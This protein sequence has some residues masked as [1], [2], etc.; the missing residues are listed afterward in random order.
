MTTPTSNIHRTFFDLP[1]DESSDIDQVE[2]LANFSS[3]GRLTWAQLLESDRVLIVSEAGVGKS[4]ECQRQQQQLWHEGESA[5]FVEL[6][7]LATDPLESQ[8]SA[9]E[10]CRFDSWLSAQTERAT[11]FLDSVDELKLT[12]GSFELTLKRFAK[13]L[14]GHLARTRIVLTTRPIAVDRDLVYRWLP[15]PPPVEVFVPETYF[16]N[17]AMRVD[18]RKDQANAS[19]VPQ[20]RFVALSPLNEQQM[21]TLATIE[22]IA[23]PA[24]L[25]QAIESQNAHDFAKRPLDF[26]ELCGDWKAYSRIRSHREQVSHNI[27]V[28]LRPRGDRRERLALAPERAREGTERLALAALLTRRF[29]IWRGQDRDRARGDSALDPSKILADWT[30]DELKTLLERPLFGFATYGRVRFHNRSVIEF[31]AAERLRGLLHKGMS[32]L[33]LKRLLFVTTPVGLPIVKPTMQPVA[34]WLA[35]HYPAIRAEVLQRDPSILLRYADPGSLDLAMRTEALQQYVV[36]YGTGGWRGQHVPAL[37]IRRLASPDL[38]PVIE[39][40]WAQGIENPEVSETLLE[41]IGAGKLTT[42]ADIAHAIAIDTDIDVRGRMDGLLALSELGDARLPHIFN[43]FSVAPAAWPAELVSA[44]IAHLFPSHMSVTQLLEALTRLQPKPREIG[45]IPT[46]LPLAIAKARL[47]EGQLA[48]LRTGLMALIEPSCSWHDQ[49]YRIAAQRQ[50]LVPALLVASRLQLAAHMAGPE[51]F[52]SIVL[53]WHLAE[54]D[55]HGSE[56]AKTLRSALSGAEAKEREAVFWAQ[57]RLI[58]RWH[59]SKNQVAWHR[60]SHFQDHPPFDISVARDS[61]WVLAGLATTTRPV[62]ERGVLFELGMQ[63]AHAGADR[64]DELKALVPL[65]ADAPELAERLGQTIVAIERPAPEPAWMREQ[66]LRSET[67]RRKQAKHLASWQ[68]LWRELIEDPDSA[69]APDRINNTT[70]NLWRVMSNE[71]RDQDVIGWNRGFIERVFNRETADRLRGAMKDV[72][73][74]DRPT[75]KSE[76]SLEGRNSY[77]MRWSMGLAGIYAEAE[78]PDWATTLS[79][80][81]VDLAARYALLELNDLPVWIDALIQ[82]RPAV[83][84][85]LIGRELLDEL[86]DENDRYSMLLQHIE[87]SSPRVIQLFLDRIRAWL[88]G[89]LSGRA[90]TTLLLGKLGRVAQLLLDYGT[91]EDGEHLRASAL[92]RL[93]GEIQ[94]NEV[95]FWLPILLNLDLATGVDVMERLAEPVSPAPHTAMTEWFA[96]MFGDRGSRNIGDLYALGSNP[97]LLLR[98]ARLAYQHVR[99]EHDVEHSGVYSPSARDH[100]EHAR[101]A[102]GNALLNAKGAE[103][104]AAKLQFSKDPLVADFRDRALAIAKEKLAEEWDA[105]LFDEAGVVRLER[106][107]DFA[108]VTRVEM[109]ALLEDRL[110]DLDDLLL[111]DTSPRE[112][113]RSISQERVVR[114]EVARALQHMAR[115]AYIV[116]QEAVTGDE[117]ETDIRLCSTASPQEGVIELKLA[118]TEYSVKDLSEALEV[119]LLQKYLAPEHRRVGCLLISIA[120]NRQWRHPSDGHL[121]DITEVVALLNTQ[122]K[123]LVD[124]VNGDVCLFVKALDLR[125]RL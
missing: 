84:E 78:D 118:E 16:A 86:N 2:F 98:L 122:A 45:G 96:A 40:L 97:S 67:W 1:T 55:V 109:A 23:E 34:A 117:K 62:D 10:K 71:I 59:P 81:E 111:Q 64:L 36:V 39:R 66:Q 99:F 116:N 70:W 5:F 90:D 9:E 114:R 107:C 91:V 76:R 100:A 104:W 18:S 26:I 25:L 12:Q 61:A 75:V 83:V 13:A 56:D 53:A 11:F 124:A 17:V 93:Q 89:V 74:Q 123:R 6:A 105:A 22:G 52:D 54:H 4:Y 47:G 41:L 103:A 95:L 48:L 87:R 51:L 63:F 106:E 110:A 42:C 14:A 7:V 92:A 57:D 37:Q 33:T 24:P 27:E 112:L 38:A 80:E 44:T 60:L 46:L 73:R 58:Q 102:L 21:R 31:L 50:D 29:T 15:M 20:W 120:T 19:K 85:T 108:P 121:M 125:A 88:Q 72:W 8:F 113:W 43:Q 68:L 119:Q 65:V 30:D 82:V 49:H 3:E 79:A 77:L 69:F 115:T 101:S 35:P 32:T 94:Q 28:K